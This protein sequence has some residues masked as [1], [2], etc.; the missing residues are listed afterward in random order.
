MVAAKNGWC[1]PGSVTSSFNGNG[2]DVVG[3]NL[4]LAM[5]L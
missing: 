4:K 3:E 1:D 5:C 2:E